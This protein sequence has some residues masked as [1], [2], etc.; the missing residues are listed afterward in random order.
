[1]TSFYQLRTGLYRPR[2]ILTCI[3][4]VL[5]ASWYLPIAQTTAQAQTQPPIRELTIGT[6]LQGRPITAVQFGNGPLKLAIVSN[7]HGGPEFATHNLA[8][9]LI[10]HF[11]ANPQEVPSNLRLYI[12]PTLNP[13]GLALGMRFNANYVDLN[14]NMNTFLDSC[15][16]N[17]WNTTVQGAYGLVSDTGGPYPDSE[18]ESRVIRSFLLDASGAIFLHNNAGLVFPAY[19]EHAPSNQM[20]E[21]YAQ[22]AN[23]IYARYWP[24]YM[25]T[26]S[27]ADWASAFGITSI[28]P[29]LVSDVDSEFEQN[30]AGVRAVLA[31][32]ESLI[33]PPEGQT[34]GEFALPAEIWRFWKAYGGESVFGLP[35]E[36]A[37]TTSNGARQRF[38]NAVLEL[39]YSA[40]DT[41]NLVRALD[42]GRTATAG[43]NFAPADPASSPV[44]FE[45]TGH[46]LRESFWYYWQRIEGERIL[47]LPISE[48]FWARSADGHM[49]IV[50]YF[51][52]GALAYY[53]EFEAT[54]Q[55]V[56][57]EPLGALDLQRDLVRAAWSSH[58]V[59]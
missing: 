6:S 35:L 4:L 29:E 34:V 9:Q 20:A 43:A 27:M 39:D 48:E 14:R 59:R 49:R 30:L 12:I 42:L 28:T 50:Q 11:R 18:V 10:E 41:P 21:V 55:A 51:E 53:P 2:T 37:Q 23:Y 56:K 24:N 47:G 7:T 58:Q 32:S 19:C 13:D 22:A 44:Y 54:G 33:F 52:R 5:L 8:N 45:Q 15:S 1:M 25:I 40:A 38:A 26:G 31:A 16:D 36:A 17:D 46:S 57:L 3:I